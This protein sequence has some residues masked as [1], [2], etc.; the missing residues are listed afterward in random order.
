M[1]FKQGVKYKISSVSYG[2]VGGFKSKIK[3]ISL[4][5]TTT[6]LINLQV[7]DLADGNGAIGADIV[8]KSYSGSANQLW[9]AV[10]AGKD[11]CHYLH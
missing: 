1:P 4:H 9:L 10:R 11:T 8:T 5:F 3:A 7:L 6:V 2:M